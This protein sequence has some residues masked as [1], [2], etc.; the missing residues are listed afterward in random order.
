MSLSRRALLGAALGGGSLVALGGMPVWA[1]GK[2]T[3]PAERLV[4]VAGGADPAFAVAAQ[5]GQAVT[6][7]GL[8]ALYAAAGWLTARPGRRLVGLLSEAD[9]MVLRQLVPASSEWLALGHHREGGSGA[10]H[11]RHQITALPASRGLAGHLAAE[12]TAQ[13]RDF[14]VTEGQ[15]AL[16]HTVAPS[17][18]AADSWQA[19]L[20]DALGRIAAGSWRPA[21][22]EPGQGFVGRGGR[23]SG[24]DIALTSFVIGG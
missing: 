10:F 18:R 17:L 13:S 20:G 7:T 11:S 21:A 8:D 16:S 1:F 2:A 5:G 14:S 19:S 3:A 6:V 23:R 24:R 4:L 9:G 22:V 15:P 12:L